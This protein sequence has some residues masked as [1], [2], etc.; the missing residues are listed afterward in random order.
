MMHQ[1]NNSR[2]I[3]KP[4]NIYIPNNLSQYIFIVLLT[5][6]FVTS[7]TNS[8]TDNTNSNSLEPSS[9]QDSTEDTSSSKNQPK[10]FV[11]K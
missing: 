1:N 5:V 10:P 8:D 3:F 2:K 7:C 6:V 9:Y 11:T 4:W